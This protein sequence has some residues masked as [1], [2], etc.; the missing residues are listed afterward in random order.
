MLFARRGL[1]RARQGKT[2]LILRKT[3]AERDRAFSRFSLSALEYKTVRSGNGAV[4][5]D[6]AGTDD[7]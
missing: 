7:R 3:R 5:V 2:V 6:P 1:R 4:Q